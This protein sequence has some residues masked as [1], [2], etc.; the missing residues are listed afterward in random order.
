M[1]APACW[2]WSY[3]LGMPEALARACVTL[4]SLA[5]HFLDGSQCCDWSSL[6]FLLWLQDTPQQKSPGN[7]REQDWVLPDPRGHRASPGPRSKVMARKGGN[8]HVALFGTEG[9]LP[10][11]SRVSLLANF[12]Y[13]NI[14]HCTGREK[15]GRSGGQCSRLTRILKGDPHECGGSLVPCLFCLQLCHT[16]DHVCSRWMDLKWRPQ[17]S[18]P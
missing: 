8:T 10:R 6:G 9:R 14:N 15:R 17:R 12:K 4:G 3:W 1:S 11:V 13:K 5:P 18:K 7:P 2:Q 16:A